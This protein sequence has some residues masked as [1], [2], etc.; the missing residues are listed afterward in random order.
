MSQ[1]IQNSDQ[2]TGLEV[3]DELENNK[4]CLD[5]QENEG[6]QTTD[7]NHWLCHT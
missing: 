1:S 7:L 6:Q 5:Q 2:R 4:K 3:E